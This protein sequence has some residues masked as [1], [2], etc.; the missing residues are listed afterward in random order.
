V[1]DALTYAL[2]VAISPFAIATVLLIL[3]SRS[4]TANAVSF[5][6]GWIS[7][8]AACAVA[9]TLLVNELDINDSEPAWM[10]VTDLAVGVGFLAVAA[11]LSIRRRSLHSAPPW[12]DAV[13]RFTPVRAATLG[14]VLSGANPKVLALSLGAT[15]S[16]AETGASA[17]L[18][19]TTVAL[20][21][22]IGAT[23]VVT[24]IAAYVAFPIQGAARLARLRQW[25]AKHERI[26]LIALALAIGGLF[27]RDG[28]DSFT[29]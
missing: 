26:V 17:S 4:A 27:I 9:F 8:V 6:A 19:A 13:D 16:L 15:L 21:I 14:V 25:L 20:F 29:S 10:R 12:V 18:T 24:P 23:G 22:V 7:G 28:I 2:G 11:K 3:S 1:R 5:A